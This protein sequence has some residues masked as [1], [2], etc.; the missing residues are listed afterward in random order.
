[1]TLNH[2][3][4][5]FVLCATTFAVAPASAAVVVITQ[6][7]VNAGGVT[8]GDTAGFPVTISRSGSYRL[9]TNLDLPPAAVNKN[10]IEIRNFDVTIDFNGFRLNGKGQGAQ[11]IFGLFNNATI[12]NGV[13]ADFKGAGINAESQAFWTVD[14]MQVLVNDG[15]TGVALG[16][17]SKVVN[18]TV[19]NN[20]GIGIICDA[21]CL[22]SSNIVN[23]NGGVGILIR[24]GTILGNTIIGNGGYGISYHAGGHLIGWGN[25][26]V[27]ANADGSLEPGAPALPLHPNACLPAC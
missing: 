21:G 14:S 5:A 20:G 25:N 23:N 15:F 22:L 11:G 4:A 18:S 24:S 12:K 13:V 6:S 9:D 8:P 17:S 3:A 2:I 16:N 19:A 7:K 1:M 27:S 10:G 26:T